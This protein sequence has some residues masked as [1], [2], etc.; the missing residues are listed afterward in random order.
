MEQVVG[1][2]AS[3][4]LDETVVVDAVGLT[5]P[6]VVV[7]RQVVRV[8]ALGH[9]RRELL[10][11]RARPRDASI[12]V[13]GVGPLR[14][15]QQVVPRLAVRVGR[16]GRLDARDRAVEVLDRQRAQVRRGSFEGVVQHGDRLVGQLGEE[17]RLP[18]AERSG[19][20]QPVQSGVRDRV[21]HALHHV[22]DRGAEG[23]QGTKVRLGPLGVLP[24]VADRH[25]A[26]LGARS[27]GRVQ[28]RG[29]RAELVG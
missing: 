20:E 9:V 26:E 14:D 24:A 3:L 5:D 25:P 6:V 28:E 13:R 1:V 18:V 15:E 21:G 17:G 7:G 4:E 10:E 29:L 2:V 8:G 27:V 12:G 16:R 22:G 19:V 11:G 23:A